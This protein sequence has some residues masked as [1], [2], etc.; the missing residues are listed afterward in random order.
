MY[1]DWKKGQY[2]MGFLANIFTFF[3]IFDFLFELCTAMTSLI[4]LGL[5]FGATILL[6]RIKLESV[7]SLCSPQ[8][9]F[10]PFNQNP[11]QITH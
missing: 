8:T 2:I 3:L 1:T 7:L 11:I 6:Y 10:Q 5:I 9:L 4:S